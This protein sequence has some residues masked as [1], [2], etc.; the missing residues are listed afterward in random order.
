M[1]RLHIRINREGLYDMLPQGLFHQP[2]Y[3][4]RYDL[5]K[6]DLLQ[7]VSI[8]RQ[9]EFF[10]RK[11]FQAFEIL[12]DETMTD[13]FLLD[14]KL[15]KKISYT[16]FVDI[17]RPYWH[18]LEK[19]T[20]VQS[21]IFLYIL[22]ILHRIRIHR[23]ETEKA[24]SI[25]LDV[26]VT[27]T[28]IRLP[29]KEAER[30]FTSKLG[31]CRL[32]DNSILGDTFDDGEWDLKLTVGS[33]SAKRMVDFIEGRKDR[34]LLDILCDMFLPVG[35]FLVTDFIIV[36]EDSMFILSDENTT[37]YLGINSFI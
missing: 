23:E 29:A 8:H 19:L 28:N 17:F 35:A 20:S 16:D 11:F 37:T 25:L 5:D 12:A 7:E 22:P 32:G 4:K 30:F 26:P 18:V 33:I 15:N 14:I 2:I 31:E 24:L 3:H 36:P 1:D 34:I 10:A 6:E 13:A 9:E 21:C 27:L